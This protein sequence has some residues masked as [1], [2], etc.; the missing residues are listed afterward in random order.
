MPSEG[1]M[2]TGIA[3]DKLFTVRALAYIAAGHYAHHVKILS[4]RY[5]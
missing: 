4:E 1:W 5:L 2:R 3:S